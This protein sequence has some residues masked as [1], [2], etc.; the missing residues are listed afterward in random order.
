MIYNNHYGQ[1]NELCITAA[2]LLFFCR[3]EFKG[4]FSCFIFIIFWLK[5]SVNR[6]RG[7]GYATKCSTAPVTVV[8]VHTLTAVLAKI[9]HCFNCLSCCVLTAKP[10]QF[11]IQSAP[12]T[13]LLM[14]NGADHQDPQQKIDS[15]IPSKK[16]EL[17]KNRVHT[18]RN[19]V[20][21]AGISWRWLNIHV[22]TGR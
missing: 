11:L 9:P 19:V 6:A 17:S 15:R 7:G 22:F 13:P 5:P 1:N 14:V 20:V 8:W 4:S 18:H 2:L 10:L 12:L 3:F 21:T 16:D